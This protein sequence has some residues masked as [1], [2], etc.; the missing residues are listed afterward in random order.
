[1]THLP[2]RLAYLIITPALAVTFAACSAGGASPAPSAPPSGDPSTAP[3]EAPATGAI[4]HKRGATDVLLRYGEGGGFMMA[5]AAATQVP[6]FTLY[7]DG[8]VIFRNPMLGFPAPQGSVMTSNPMRTAKLSEEQIQELLVLALGD[9]GLA[10]AR[11]D[12]AN[13]MVADASTAEFTID[14]GGV[15]KTVSVYALGLETPNGADAQARAAFK[16]LADTLSD[17]DQGGTIPT[18]VYEPETYRGVLLESPGMDA[19]DLRAWPWTDITT[20]DFTT[21]ADPDG[22]AFP[23]RTMT[24]DEIDVL[25]VQDYE[26]GFAGLPLQGTDDKLYTMSLRPLLP[27]DEG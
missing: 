6:T 18:E 14:A 10:T 7:G 12:Y 16:E 17:F 2:R 8:T 19:P 4:D 15:Q 22:I 24:T 5:G 26:G 9:G 20:E 3:S 1:M 11:A 25:E 23:H 27:D 13:D 21:D